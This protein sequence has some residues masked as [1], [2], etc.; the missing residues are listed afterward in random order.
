M[1]SNFV[2]KGLV[3]TP[4]WDSLQSVF[5]DENKS[6]NQQD[7]AVATR[8]KPD[9]ALLPTTSTRSKRGNQS[10]GKTGQ[11]NRLDQM[12]SGLATSRTRRGPRKPQLPP[13]S[14][15]LMTLNE[16]ENESIPASRSRA[17]S[18]KINKRDTSGRS[19]DRGRNL[20]EDLEHSGGLVK[21]P[22]PLRPERNRSNPRRKPSKIKERGTPDDPILSSA[23][24]AASCGADQKRSMPVN[25]CSANARVRG[26]GGLQALFSQDI[27]IV[28]RQTD[29]S[30]RAVDISSEMSQQAPLTRRQ[31]NPKSQ[32]TKHPKHTGFV[33]ESHKLRRSPTLLANGDTV[34]PVACS[35]ISNATADETMLS[36]PLPQASH[37]RRQVASFSSPA[38]TAVQLKRPD[39]KL[40]P[41]RLLENDT[42]SSALAKICSAELECVGAKD[43]EVRAIECVGPGH[44]QLQCHGKTLPCVQAKVDLTSDHTAEVP[45]DPIS[46]RAYLVQP[47]VGA[48]ELPKSELRN[49]GEQNSA[50][51]ASESV[52]TRRDGNHCSAH[53]ESNVQDGVTH[54]EQTIVEQDPRDLKV[55]EVLQCPVGN[56]TVKDVVKSDDSDRGSCN[57]S[58]LHETACLENEKAD[59]CVDSCSNE[60]N[61]NIAMFQHI[62]ASGQGQP[63]PATKTSNLREPSLHAETS[64]LIDDAISDVTMSVVTDGQMGCENDLEIPCIVS[65]PLQRAALRPSMVENNVEQSLAPHSLSDEDTA[66][67]DVECKHSLS[68]LFVG[69]KDSILLESE[70]ESQME[71]PV[72]KQQEG[73]IFE[74]SGNSLNGNRTA[75]ALKPG[76]GQ[77]KKERD[78]NHMKVEKPKS[79]IPVKKSQTSKSHAVSVRRSTRQ[80]AA[81]ARLGATVRC[82]AVK[83]RD[84]E[85]RSEDRGPSGTTDETADRESHRMRRKEKTDLKKKNM[86]PQ[87]SSKVDE[88]QNAF[89]EPTVAS[90][91]VTGRPQRMRQQP[92]RFG[93]FVDISDQEDNNVDSVQA[94]TRKP[95]LPGDCPSMTVR[96]TLN[97]LLPGDSSPVT[98]RTVD[99]LRSHTRPEPQMQ[100][101]FGQV[102]AHDLAH[103]K[104]ATDEWSTQQ[105]NLLR[106]AYDRADPTSSTFWMDVTLLANNGKSS[107]E[108]RDKWFSLV[109]TPQPPR[110]TGLRKV[111]LKS[112][113]S[114]AIA[115]ED[116]IFNSTPMRAE[117]SMAV[118]LLSNLKVAIQ[119]EE[120]GENEDDENHFIDNVSNHRG[121][122]PGLKTY[123]QAMRRDMLRSKKERRKKKVGQPA[124]KTKGTILES[125][126]D[127]D[128]DM[129]IRLTPGGTLR[130]KNLDNEEDDFWDELYEDEDED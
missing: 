43:R 64:S 76:K 26:G 108:C 72:G 56:A 66:K 48:S 75:T 63:L 95:K 42:Q 120:A 53:M 96:K 15:V 58:P 97:S 14:S 33:D 127:G 61:R 80:R 67:L 6:G 92:E 2:R 31:V 128:V 16:N 3:P 13:T 28:P 46:C 91:I 12:R 109:K 78:R 105:L 116:D 44:C 125:R 25:A 114:S 68:P 110:G 98:T 85:R 86:E 49:D 99:V 112:V 24:A 36:S 9:Q 37:K 65:F 121:A 57:R 70:R 71:G 122:K 32:L 83:N 126:H 27:P 89:V 29:S 40:T 51:E 23:L 130:V 38:A 102:D 115:D 104:D 21:I 41:V 55:S 8:R 84:T 45:C 74:K 123:I 117:E 60:Q 4:V 93:N 82:K 103:S 19:K 52:T 124:I 54:P 7:E 73:N 50:E 94:A 100:Q 90:T 106:E 30:P 87:D 107:I 111:A 47:I 59:N 101:D 39:T 62:Q 10:H 88:L 113:R 79:K 34:E 11:Q 118:K 17:L 77:A 22:A 20:F 129:D 18:S 119:E 69:V 1:K 35:E 5:V 81:P